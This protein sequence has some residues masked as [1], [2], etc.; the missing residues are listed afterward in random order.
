MKRK[1]KNKDQ[2]IQ[3]YKIPCLDI[4]LFNKKES[5]LKKMVSIKNVKENGHSEFTIAN[6]ILILTSYPPRVCGIA[7]YTKDLIYALNNKFSSS[8]TL[9]ICALESGKNGFT[10]PNEVK[11]ILDTSHEKEF[12][13]LAENINSDK[14][15]S[16]VFIQHEFGLFIKQRKAFLNFLRILKKPIIATFHT[17]LANPDIALID[18][19]SKIVSRCQ[20][21][22]VMTHTSRN[23]LEQQYNID[24]AKI[25]VI[26]H[27]T[28][29]VSLLSKKVLKEKYGL[30]GKKV[31]STFGLLSS[32][33][34]IETTINALPEIIKEFPDVV[35]L[36]LGKTHP[37]VVKQEGEQYREMLEKKIADLD[38]GKYVIFHNQY[39]ELD[40]LLEYLQLTDI[41]LFTTNDPNQAVSG[42]FVY[43]MSCGCPIISTP[44]PHAREVLTTE[45]GIIV[46]FCNSQQLA[47][48]VLKLLKNKPLRKSMVSNTLEKIVSTAWE[49]SATEH[50]FLFKTIANKNTPLQFNIPEIKLSHLLKMTTKTG[51]IQFSQI[52]QPDINSGYTLDDNARALISCGMYLELSQNE[53]MIALMFKYLYF[54]KFCQQRDG[55]FLNYVDKNLQFSEKNQEV[56]LDD[57]NGRAVWAVGYIISLNTILPLEMIDLAKK[58]LRRS[59]P[60]VSNVNSPRAI[61]FAIKGLYYSLLPRKSNKKLQLLTSL[62]NKLVQMYRHETDQNWQWFE[63][64]MTYANSVLPE[65]LILAWDMT[66]DPIYKKI[67]ISSFDFLLSKTFNVNGIE[68]ISNKSWLKKGSLPEKFGEQPLDVA[69]TILTLNTFY[70]MFTEKQY[71]DKMKIAFSWFLGNNR[72]HQIIYNPS[73]GGCYDGLE[74]SNVNINQGAESLVSY[75]MA[76]I[77]IDK[78]KDFDAKD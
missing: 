11:Y 29:L 24:S 31:L 5:F 71:L 44:I 55:S 51:I 12:Y 66:N 20:S 39:L 47:Q 38:I 78:Y 67:A 59:I 8:F 65:S 45:T 1:M 62:S 77:I 58:I 2:S 21:V 26:A 53:E 9:K 57:S 16:T 35:F 40:E 14:L 52:N 68:V 72:L 48:G 27:G 30:T 76:R 54:I 28:H 15:I 36:V 61:A 50:A 4:E 23:I 73:T 43:A 19:I 46:D 7:T 13:E 49:N 41:Y 75:L 70:D 56:N 63:K 22:V 10:Y 17:V 64:Y 3:M 34:S 25:H 6:E 60:F 69:Y 18:E 32:G 37:E 42:T 74:K 33:K